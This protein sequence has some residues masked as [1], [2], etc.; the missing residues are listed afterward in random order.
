MTNHT[1]W[2]MYAENG[3]ILTQLSKN[4]KKQMFMDGYIQE[5][6]MYTI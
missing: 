2:E 6:S 4:N 1:Q 5:I 3:N